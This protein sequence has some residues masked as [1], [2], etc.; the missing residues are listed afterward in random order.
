MPGRARP[1]VDHPHGRAPF[2]STAWGGH[3]CTGMTLAENRL[4]SLDGYGRRFRHHFGRESRHAPYAGHCGVASSLSAPSGRCATHGIRLLAAR[5]SDR[6]ARD[7]ASGC[8]RRSP[9]LWIP[10]VRRADSAVV[11]VFRGDRPGAPGPASCSKRV[12]Q[13]RILGGALYTWEQYRP[14][15]PWWSVGARS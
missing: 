8:P 7:R 14:A 12:P 1:A 3:Q 9:Q 6:V 4:A 15:S 13:V 10:G 5:S 2:R 11:E